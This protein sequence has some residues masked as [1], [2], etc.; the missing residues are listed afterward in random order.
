MTDLKQYAKTYLES[1]GF[2]KLPSTKNGC[3]YLYE[4]SKS[5][6][7][8]T[9]WATVNFPNCDNYDTNIKVA[10]GYSGAY[11]GDEGY[12]I[13]SYSGFFKDIEEF[14]QILKLTRVDEQLKK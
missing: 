13:S 12:H 9:Y 3:T 8:G 10:T 11:T 7:G 5:E 6:W 14:L 1:K 4:H 2:F